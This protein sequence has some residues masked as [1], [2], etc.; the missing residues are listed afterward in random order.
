MALPWGRIVVEELPPSAIGVSKDQILLNA[1]FEALTDKERIPFSVESDVN[2]QIGDDFQLSAFGLQG[3][4]VG[5]LN[6]AQKDKGPFILGEVNIRNGQYRSFGQDLQIKEG[7]ILMNGPVDQPYLAITAI[8]NPNNTQDGVVAG[9]RV[10]G[11][12]D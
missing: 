8:R 7:K 4:L 6:V 2:V 9:V 11:P 1:D 5:R 10:S 12:S 3:N